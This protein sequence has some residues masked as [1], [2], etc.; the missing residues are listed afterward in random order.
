MNKGQVKSNFQMPQAASPTRNHND[1]GDL[2]TTRPKVA[3][4]TTNGSV[5][6]LLLNLKQGDEISVNTSFL[7]GTWELQ[8]TF[9]SSAVADLTKTTSRQFTLNTTGATTGLTTRTRG[10]DWY[11][12]GLNIGGGKSP[13]HSNL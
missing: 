2:I 3:T 8:R 12:Y 6:Y 10:K 13:Q 11:N 7:R 4:I 9:W 5:L 1:R